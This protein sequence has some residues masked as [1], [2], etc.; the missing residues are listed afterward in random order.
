MLHIAFMGTPEFA[1]PILQTLIA[2]PDINIKAVYTQPG[3]PSGRGQKLQLTPVHQ[4]AEAHHLHVRTPHTLKNKEEQDYF[5]SLQLDMAI[6]VA[7][8]LI[9]P[10][11]ILQAPK[12]GCLNIHASLLPKW[13]GA[14]PIQRAIL[15]GDTISGITMM[16]MDEGLDT[17]P[18]WCT[19]PV[20]ISKT[21][22]SQ[23]L[24]HALSEVAQ[25][26]LLP[27]VKGIV[28]G[29]LTAKPQPDTNISYAQKLSREEGIINWQNEA[30]YIDRQIRALNPWPGTSFVANNGEIIK[31]LKAHIVD[32][33]GKPGCILD[34]QLTIACGSQAIQPELL[35]RPGKKP[36][37][38]S[39]FLRGFPIKLIDH[40]L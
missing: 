17:G 35:Q 4:L 11:P 13:R 34:D 5:A 19:V 22:T 20:A 25:Q 23:D 2:A 31:I 10:L 26:M 8:G 21:T 27:T 36:L 16:Q 33:T 15:A 24:F 39:E 40:A 32:K 30:S 37:P 9:L 6:V 14:A 1:V 12:F 18:I 38:L 28:E 7:Y 29:T 3:R